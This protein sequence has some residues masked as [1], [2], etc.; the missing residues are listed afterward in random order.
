MELIEEE[1]LPG[2]RQLFFRVRQLIQVGQRGELFSVK[3]RFLCMPYSPFGLRLRC[4]DA[5]VILKVQLTVPDW[6]FQVLAFANIRKKST[7]SAEL[8][9][10]IDRIRRHQARCLV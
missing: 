1:S 8:Y 7:R 6:N 5:S 10:G 9:L 3:K 4:E 2:S